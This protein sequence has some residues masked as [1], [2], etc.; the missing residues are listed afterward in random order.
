MMSDTPPVPDD[1]VPETAARPVWM[2]L[3]PVFLIAA[4]LLT[5]WQFG[6]FGYFSLDTLKTQQDALNGYVAAHPFLAFGVFI[7]LYALVTIFMLPGAGVVTMAGGFMFGLVQGSLATIIG[8][9]LG[10]S[11]LFVAART[12][13]GESLRQRAGPFLRKMEAGFRED[14]FSY[15]FAL[16]FIP[17]VPFPV[18]NIAPAL[19]GARYRDF[20]ITTSLG[21]I[22]GVIAYTLIGTG[23]G[24]TFAAGEDPDFASVTRNLLPAVL[25]LLAVSLLPVVYKKFFRKPGKTES[26]IS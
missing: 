1:T 11:I 10:A 14:A 12:S 16:R 19:L 20:L 22:P 23:L 6:L 24:A 18:A 5:A 3:W 17:V 9:T 2:R 8:A 15:M 7:V 25:A 21:I 13:I 4:G 26:R